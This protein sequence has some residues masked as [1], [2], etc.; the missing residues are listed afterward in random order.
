MIERDHLLMLTWESCFREFLG[1]V[2]L[3]SL[4]HVVLDAAS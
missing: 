2:P 4:D 3:Q 1:Q